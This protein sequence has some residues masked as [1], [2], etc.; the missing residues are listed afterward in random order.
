M[1]IINWYS[2]IFVSF[3]YCNCQ[4]SNITYDYQSMALHQKGQHFFIFKYPSCD[5]NIWLP[6]YCTTGV[7]TALCIDIKI[8]FVQHMQ[9]VRAPYTSRFS[10]VRCRGKVGHLGKSENA[11]RRR[12]LLMGRDNHLAL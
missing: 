8:N 1:F 7:R 3:F 12:M 5:N 11:L 4:T 10:V 6:A 9:S 2:W